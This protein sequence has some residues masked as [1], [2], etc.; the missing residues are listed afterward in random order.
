MNTSNETV[1]ASSS[2]PATK[3][4]INQLS[5]SDFRLDENQLAVLLKNM[6]DE[7]AGIICKDKLLLEELK[8]AFLG[9]DLITWLVR[10]YPSWDR[11]KARKFSQ[12]LLQTSKIQLSFVG[13]HPISDKV[14]SINNTEFVDDA[15]HFYK[16][17]D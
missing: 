12:F 5:L 15:Y 16:F 6:K 11:L 10:H 3:P 13:A 4:K 17:C 9:R 14:N 8:V 1:L 2:V 7:S